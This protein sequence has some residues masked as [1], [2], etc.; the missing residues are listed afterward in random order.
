MLIKLLGQVMPGPHGRRHKGREGVESGESGEPGGWA[1]GT[2]LS[3]P[4]SSALT[5]LH[6]GCCFG[7]K[8]LRPLN[9]FPFLNSWRG[10]PP[11][12]APVRTT[13]SVSLRRTASPPAAA[14]AAPQLKKASLPP[15][16]LH[17]DSWGPCSRKTWP[18]PE[19]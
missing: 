11:R 17:W 12:S 9:L 5:S 3:H 1:V 16:V 15:A 6:L 8:Y 10:G 19:A 13:C 4:E 7:S 18:L 14:S 2:A